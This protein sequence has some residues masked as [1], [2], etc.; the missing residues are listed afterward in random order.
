M[1]PVVTC[2]HP[3]RTRI[4]V[5]PGADKQTHIFLLPQAAR[6]PGFR[7]STFPQTRV[8]AT[9]GPSTGTYRIMCP[10]NADDPPLECRKPGRK[11]PVVAESLAAFH[12]PAIRQSRG[13]KE[14]SLSVTTLPV[15]RG[16]PAL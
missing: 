13:A 3:R 15:Y 10:Q 6:F 12:N 2:D 14:S 9:T 4:L 5:V 16:I 8:P 7:F 11:R 1:S